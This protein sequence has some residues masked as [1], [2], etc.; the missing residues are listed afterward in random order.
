MYNELKPENI[1]WGDAGNFFPSFLLL[2]PSPFLKEFF[3][4]CKGADYVIESSGAF[5]TTEKASSHLKGG[6]KKVVISAPSADAPMFV[7]GVNHEQYEPVSIFS[8]FL[9]FLGGGES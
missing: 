6:A 5:T 2:F 7:V 1:K 4:S 9:L 8:F 3:F